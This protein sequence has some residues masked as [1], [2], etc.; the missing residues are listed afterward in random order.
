MNNS[1]AMVPAVNAVTPIRKNLAG[2]GDGLPT[3]EK[4]PIT[5]YQ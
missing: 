1:V 3:N 4:L 2:V 5:N